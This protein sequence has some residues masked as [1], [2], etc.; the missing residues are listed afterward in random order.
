M[1]VFDYVFSNR[2]QLKMV[3]IDEKGQEPASRIDGR[4]ISEWID[5]GNADA[6]V[7]GD[8]KALSNKKNLDS[9]VA[10]D[11]WNTSPLVPT[12]NA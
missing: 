2:T 5:I 6:L 7:E 10:F 4:R 8:I 1:N 12:M 9:P 11:L 3:S